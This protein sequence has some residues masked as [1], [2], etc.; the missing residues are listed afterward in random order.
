V[1]WLAL[2]VFGGVGLFSFVYG[3]VWGYQGYVLSRDGVTTQGHVVEVERGESRDDDGGTSVSYHPVVEFWSAG[4]KQHRFTGSGGSRHVGD[5]VV[6]ATVSVLYDPGNPANARIADSKQN[7]EQ[8]LA[9][10]LFGFLF[11]AGGIGAFFMSGIGLSRSS[12]KTFYPKLDQKIT[13]AAR[14]QDRF[15]LP[16]G[17]E[18]ILLKGVVDSVRKQHGASREEYV[19]ICRATL[20][21]AIRPEH[22]EAAPISFHPGRR[23]VGKSVEIYV[24]RGDKT[25]DAVKL[26]PVLAE[27]QSA[28]R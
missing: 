2:L 24:H 19:V 25:R 23:I 1:R 5:I 15:A 3:C 22:F 4:E 28:K 18:G 11:L 8:P 14:E 27:L 20:P 10:G 13:K 21:G 7:W 6:G 9:L 16:E 12:D 26:E 17:E